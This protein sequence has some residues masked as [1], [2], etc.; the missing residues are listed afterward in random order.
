MA[1]ETCSR[2]LRPAAGKNASQRTTAGTNAQTRQ[3]ARGS[4]ARRSWGGMVRHNR[5]MTLPG[6]LHHRVQGLRHNL[7]HACSRRSSGR[8]DGHLDLDSTIA[9]GEDCT[10]MACFGRDAIFSRT[11]SKGEESVRA[12]GVYPVAYAR[13]S[14]RDVPLGRSGAPIRISGAGG[15]HTFCAAEGLRERR[16]SRARRG[17][18]RRSHDVARP[19]RAGASDCLH[20]TIGAGELDPWYESGDDGSQSCR[21][22]TGRVRDLSRE[23]HSMEYP[24][25]KD[26]WWR[27]PV[28]G[29]VCGGFRPH[30]R[31][32][33][34]S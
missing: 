25:R 15:H 32:D 3:N 11:F 13:S 23:R 26:T 2:Y 20:C 24:V 22:R 7:S 19:V 29:R 5:R 21:A 31:V 27:E 18:E 4:F 12:A 28:N 34:R 8:S 6:A 10:V 1:C 33:P 14:R 17:D 30:A 16:E 9:H